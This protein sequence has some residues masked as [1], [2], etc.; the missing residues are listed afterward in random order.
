[1]AKNYM[2]DVAKLLGIE[3]EEEFMVTKMITFIN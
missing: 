3:L 2:A 1:M